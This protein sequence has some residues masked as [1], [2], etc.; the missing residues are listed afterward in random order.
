MQVSDTHMM[1]SKTVKIVD[2]AIVCACRAT[3]LGC[4]FYVANNKSR[5]DSAVA[6]LWSRLLASPLFRHET[7]E[8]MLAAASFFVWINLWRLF[9][10]YG[11]DIASAWRIRPQK[12]PYKLWSGVSFKFWRQQ[13]GV[14]YG[15]GALLGYLLPLL[16]FDLIVPRRTRAMS[17]LVGSSNNASLAT[18]AHSSTSSQLD[19]DDGALE[20][21][22]LVAPPPTVMLLVSQ[23]VA[24]LLVYDA[25]HFP[26]HLAQH[27][28]LLRHSWPSCSRWLAKI[29]APHHKP[30]AELRAG[31]VVQHSFAD[32][33]L[34]VSCNVAALWLCRSHPLARAAHNIVV[35]ALLTEAHCGFDV[36]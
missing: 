13:G 17:L 36:P 5:A 34:Q 21:V 20:A 27:G 6:L 30:K 7:F 23:V 24:S 14:S 22:L 10:A 32:G 8:P 26:L 31:H 29:H 9:D 3:F 19:G 4:A 2:T 28:L 12:Q 1:K 18:A 33:A 11:G 35:T 25:L 15:A 16:A